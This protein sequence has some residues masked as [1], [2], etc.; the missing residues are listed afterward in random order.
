MHEITICLNCCCH[1]DAGLEL[2][3]KDEIK[4]A[5]ADFLDSGECTEDTFDEYQ[6]KVQCSSVSSNAMLF[7]AIKAL[8]KQVSAALFTIELL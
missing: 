4:I 8:I 3:G 2:L 7:T 6:Q 1:Q 5:L